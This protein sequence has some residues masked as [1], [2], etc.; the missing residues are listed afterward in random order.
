MSLWRDPQLEQEIDEIGRVAY[1]RAVYYFAS[2]FLV[3]IDVAA[4]ALLAVPPL[5]AALPAPI[6]PLVGH[7]AGSAVVAVVA[8][9]FVAVV[10]QGASRRVS[11]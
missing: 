1:R 4:V 8:V 10:L 5:R 3:G 2:L 11:R 6:G 9:A 7:V